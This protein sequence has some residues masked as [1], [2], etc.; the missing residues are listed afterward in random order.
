MTLSDISD[1]MVGFSLS[2][3]NS[4]KVLERLTVDP[5]G[6]LKFMGCGSYDLG[7]L[8]CKIGRLSLTGELG[9]EI[10]CS[11]SEHIALRKMLLEA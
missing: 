7:L 4:R 6:D 9:Y 2:G 8:K 1:K 5:I 3:P 11:A 10:N